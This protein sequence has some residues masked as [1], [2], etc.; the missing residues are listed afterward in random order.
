MKKI[1]AVISVICI[2]SILTGFCV[3]S[4]AVPAEE[5]SYSGT[6]DGRDYAPPVETAEIEDS[7][8]YYS[9][10]STA[11]SYAKKYFGASD[12]EADFSEESLTITAGNPDIHNFGDVLYKSI[13]CDIGND[14]A[15]TSVEFLNGRGERYLKEKISEN[16]A[17]VAAIAVPAE[18]GLTNQTYYNSEENSFAYTTPDSDNDKY[19]AVS[20]VGWDDDYDRA[21]FNKDEKGKSLGKTNGAWICKNSYGTDF[22]DGGYFYMSY[23][24]PLVYAAALEVSQVSGVSLTLK[25]NQLLKYVGFIYGVNVRAYSASTEEITVTV[26]NKTAFSGE[27]ELKNGCNLILF[28][29]PVSSRKVS[30][31][32]NGISTS[33]D[34][35]YCYYSFLPKNRMTV[36]P[37]IT[38]KNW[39]EDVQDIW[40]SVENDNEY[41]SS[42]MQSADHIVRKNSIDNCCYITPADGYRFT[43]ETIIV[44]IDGFDD[45]YLYEIY[46]D[47]YCDFEAFSTIKEAIDADYKRLK[48]SDGN[49]IKMIEF[50]PTFDGGRGRLKIVGQGIGSA[51]VNE[52]NILTDENG[53]IKSTVLTFDDGSVLTVPAEFS[54]FKDEN[55]T[56]SINEISG[57]DE[58]FAEINVS[59]Y[60]SENLTVKINGVMADCEINTDGAEITVNVKISVPDITQTIAETFRSIRLIFA[61]LIEKLR[62][63]RR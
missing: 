4:S 28:D 22:G 15:I 9:I 25:P 17:I 52:L 38:D 34:T 35:F 13:G 55:R 18:N 29:K 7:C 5:C 63:K 39:L 24:T 61:K 36:K 54:L 45:Y 51:Y 59:G 21:K 12:A 3:I 44:G 2:F 43:W 40:I 11:G 31:T 56:E 60:Y 6:L 42:T 20:I 26:G 50:D 58:Y 23:T 62:F 30:I 48:D 16:G 57:L 14:Y 33:P 32:G 49:F 8:L 19:H 37:A 41:C 46:G 27:V 10:L 53:A 1:K 47:D